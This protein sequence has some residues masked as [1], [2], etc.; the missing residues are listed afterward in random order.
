MC[1][2]D[3]TR[4]ALAQDLWPI[5]VCPGDVPGHITLPP[6]LDPARKVQVELAIHDAP[7]LRRGGG[8][9]TL[10]HR[11]GTKAPVLRRIGARVRGKD[12]AV[13]RADKAP[14][15]A[16]PV[17][18]DARV[19]RHGAIFGEIGDRVRAIYRHAIIGIDG[20]AALRV[21][22]PGQDQGWHGNTKAQHCA[23][24]EVH[25]QASLGLCEGH[26]RGERPRH[27]TGHRDVME[28]YSW[29]R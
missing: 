3:V 13:F 10:A 4:I 2:V 27:Q 26:L 12:R 9:V 7:G 24:V 21:S 22:E 23:T 15:H 5:R 17:M 16:H 20:G 14:G 25:D 28:C 11:P 18:R 19:A 8:G 6:P 29:V 1:C